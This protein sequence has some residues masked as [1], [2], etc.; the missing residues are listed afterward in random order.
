MIP[1]EGSPLEFEAQVIAAFGRHLIVRDDAGR[2]HAARPFG[3]R[4]A[5]V[6][7]DRLRCRTDESHGE[8]HAIEVLPR[9]SALLRSSARGDPEAI[10]ANISL[11][12]VVVAPAPAP[13]LFMV[14]RY[15]CAAASN[16]IH[17]LLVLNKADLP[18]RAELLASLQPL[19]AAGYPIV[20]CTAR[21]DGDVAALATALAG[22]TSALVGQSGVGKSSLVGQLVPEA[23]VLTGELDR[24]L[25][26]RHTTTRSRLYDLQGGGKLIDSPGVRDFAPAI[27]G[28]EPGSLG[29]VEVDRLSPGCRFMDCRHM[30][31]PGCAV[32][33]AATAGT[34]DPRRYESYRRLRRLFE[35]LTAAQG[36][37][38]RGPR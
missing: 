1:H 17:A 26:G 15:L 8:V 7:G 33:A 32:I 16:S 10:V 12:A 18:G 3:R 36:P 6:C 30:R 4:L 37:S 25:E 14:D 38:R 19:Q 9:R 21:G 27:Q 35:E 5:I 23:T 31:E 13:D 22:H 2:E 20:E 28:L 29:F 24:E 11:L 34:L